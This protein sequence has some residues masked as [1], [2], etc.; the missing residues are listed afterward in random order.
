MRRAFRLVVAVVAL[1]GT[2]AGARAEVPEVRLSKQYGLPYL[3]F[4][5]MEQFALLEKQAEKSG[6]ALKVSWTTLSNATAMMDAILSGQMDFITPGVPTL[7][8]M[9]DKTAGTPNEIRALSA[10]QSMP[11]VLVTRAD[12]IK[13]IRDFSEKDRIALPAVKLTG[14]AIALQMAAAREWGREHYDRLDAITISLSHPDATA[15]LLAGKGEINA[16][17]ASSPFYYIELATPGVHKV[18]HS[19]EVAGGRHTNGVLMASKK[20][21]DANPKICA[22]VVAALDEAN[23]FIKANP[24]KAAEIYIAMAKE[25]RSTLDEMEKMVSDPDVDYTTTPINVMKFVEFMNLAGTVKRKPSSWKD[26]FFPIAY[27]RPGS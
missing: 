8:T 26:L 22:A 7:A 12:H 16:H 11:Y 2:L 14:H 15:A 3:P 18:L 9:W 25:K 19:Y 6:F 23:A 10:V 17:F 1:A 5:V 21:Y 4:M 13:S 24:R 27:E 20:F